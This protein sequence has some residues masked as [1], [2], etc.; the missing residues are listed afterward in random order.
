MNLTTDFVK[1]G[2]VGGSAFLVDMTSLIFFTEM[3]GFHYLISA[4]ISFS[5]ALTF[6]YILCIK[7][8]FKFHVYNNYGVEFGL[9]SIIGLIGIFITEVLLAVLTPLLGNYLIAKIISCAVVLFWNFFM[10]RYL[11]FIPR[12]IGE[13]G[14]R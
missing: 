3:S 8:I 5:M 12:K 6:N 14:I 1:Y 11:L 2:V 10:R 7:W 9:F 13:D 4:P